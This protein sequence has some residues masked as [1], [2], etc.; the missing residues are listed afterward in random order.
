MATAIQRIFFNL[1]SSYL[2]I[3]FIHWNS[4]FS[5]FPFSLSVTSYF[6]SF[7]NSNIILLSMVI[8]SPYLIARILVYRTITP[9]CFLF[10]IVSFICFLLTTSLAQITSLTHLPS[11]FVYI[12]CF[13]APLP[14]LFQRHII[15]LSTSYLSPAIIS[16][17]LIIASLANTVFP[18]PPPKIPM[19]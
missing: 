14:P 12:L 16:F 11:A 18:L 2:S 17:L 13:I 4:Y 6:S 1:P 10:T 15:L 3:Y 5:H 8:F 19:H 9:D 7:T